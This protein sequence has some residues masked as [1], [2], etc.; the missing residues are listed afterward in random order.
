MIGSA[1]T[2]SEYSR[3]AKNSTPTLK[4][5]LDEKKAAT[6]KWIQE[7]SKA[8]NESQKQ[9][10]VVLFNMGEPFRLIVHMSIR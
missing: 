1:L 8:V 10:W 2:L 7:I 5:G 6:K 3:T 4:R 9:S